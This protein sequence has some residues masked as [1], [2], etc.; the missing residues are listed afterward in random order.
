M[1]FTAVNVLKMRAPAG[2]AD[3]FEWDDATPG[4]GIRFRDGGHGTFIVKFFVNGKQGKMSLGKVGQISFDDAKTAAQRQLATVKIEKKNPLVERAKEAAAAGEDFTAQIDAFLGELANGVE[5]G[6]RPRSPHYVIQ[7][8]SSLRV[9]LK[10]LHIYKLG[11][12]KRR[13]VVTA[14]DLIHEERGY[15]AA[16]CAQAHLSSY[17]GFCIRK[18]YEGFNPV[19][20]TERRNSKARVRKHSPHE[21]LLIWRATEE[22]TRFNRIV[23]LLMLT[24]MRKTVIADLMRDEVKLDRHLIDI[25]RVFGKAKNGEEFLLPMSR[26]VEAMVRDAMKLSN[27]DLIFSR[28]DDEGGFGCWTR[29]KEELDER[30]TEL[31]GGQEIPHWVFHDF[32][33]TF[34]SL[35]FDICKIPDNIAD[36]CLYHI[37][38][39]KK[40]LNGVYNKATYL[41]E[42][43]DAMQRWADFIDELVHGKREFKVVS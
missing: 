13:T 26:Q 27:R 43:R 35:G 11:D 33:R 38:E 28:G 9:L 1:K 2:V 39:A 40:G 22:P 25:P 19:D 5:G 16:G 36:V 21:L 8:K 4:F 41:D 3:H 18:G 14:L 12:I 31:N 24:G 42:K 32:R 15:R 10:D 20:G 37:G 30:I 7:V 23:R 6:R 34:R 29:M 17:Y